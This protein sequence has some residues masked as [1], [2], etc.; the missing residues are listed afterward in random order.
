MIVSFL[1]LKLL[2]LKIE[3]GAAFF[4]AET[5]KTWR[6][7]T[8]EAGRTRGESLNSVGLGRCCAS[9]ISLNRGVIKDVTDANCN[10]RAINPF[11]AAQHA[12]SLCPAPIVSRAT[13]FA[14]N[15]ETL[16]R[17]GEKKKHEEAAKCGEEKGGSEETA[18]GANC[19]KPRQ[20]YREAGPLFLRSRG[21]KRDPET[22]A[23]YLC[24]EG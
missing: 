17:N 6:R 7:G 14:E 3:G 12:Q 5:V 1:A 9:R 20:E 21:E 4:Q 10:T 11:S 23:T 8:S 16:A 24:G 15:L 2:Y 18:P 22:R 19:T 13:S